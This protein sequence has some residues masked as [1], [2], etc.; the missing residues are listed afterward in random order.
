MKG[1]RMMNAKCNCGK[2]LKPGYIRC[3]RCEKPRQVTPLKDIHTLVQD[4]EA[5]IS[6]LKI[7]LGRQRTELR[8]L[9]K[10]LRAM[11]D[12]VRFSHRVDRDMKK[13]AELD[14]ALAPAAKLP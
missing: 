6:S 9:N 13:A 14:A 11:W 10:T 1:T 3:W 2:I 7:K 12:G 8:R 5:D 4:Q